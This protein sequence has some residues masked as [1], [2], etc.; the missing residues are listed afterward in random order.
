MDIVLSPRSKEPLYRQIYRQI[1]AQ[2][3]DGSLSANENL[4]SVRSA[5]RYL[6]VAVITVKT[7]YEELEKDGFIYALPAKGYFVAESSYSRIK[8]GDADVERACENFLDV[9]L[10]NGMSEE[11]I[12][13]VLNND[14][15]E[16]IRLC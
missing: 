9:C 16:R 12:L 10:S 2:I 11:E 14:L 5:A 7:A 15:K 3:R 1:I 6:G 8:K 13:T 4:L